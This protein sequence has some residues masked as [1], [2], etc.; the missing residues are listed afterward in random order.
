MFPKLPA[1]YGQWKALAEITFKAI[2]GND[3]LG[4]KLT[5]VGITPEKVAEWLGHISIIEQLRLTAEK[6]DREAQQTSQKK[7]EAFSELKNYCSD[8]RE[9][10]NLFYQGSERQKLE[11]VGIVVK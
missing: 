2:Q 4:Q 10:L 1:N 3:D 6:E 7:Q 9:C 8:L 11:E 5:L